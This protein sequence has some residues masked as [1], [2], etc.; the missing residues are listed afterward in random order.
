MAL[1][2]DLLENHEPLLITAHLR[3]GIGYDQPYGLDLAGVLASR[4]RAAD[5]AARAPGSLVTSP[6]PDTT[7]EEPED[8]DLPLGR[9]LTGSDWHWT[10]SCA[11]PVAPEPDPEPRTFYR[12]V[13]AAWS[14][15][16]AERPLPYIHPS[17]GPHRDMMMPAPVVLCNA[18]QWHAIGNREEI[19]RLLS[20]VKFMGRRRSV[21]EGRIL[22]WEVEGLGVSSTEEGWSHVHEG[23]IVRPCPEECAQ[24]LDVPYRLGWYALRPPSWHP[25]RLGQVAMTEEP[26]EEW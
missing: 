2:L 15:R 10:A 25:D 4:M 19:E 14:H 18:V 13:D 3:T 17:K 23:E 11:I 8:M 5:R 1:R 6:L 22:E 26:E 21:G 12:V 7:E 24:A 16:A 20:G 9:C